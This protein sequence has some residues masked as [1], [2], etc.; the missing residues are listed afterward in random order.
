VP[1][2]LP[3]LRPNA[4]SP[5][6]SPAVNPPAGPANFL[7]SDAADKSVNI[8]YWHTELKCTNAAAG[9][10]NDHRLRGSTGL[11]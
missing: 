9:G 4:G 7:P 5:G 11:L 3:S 6:Q 10:G 1:P 8:H 2:P